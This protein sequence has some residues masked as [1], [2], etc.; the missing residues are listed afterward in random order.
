MKKELLIRFVAGKTNKIESA[1]VL[2]WADS[3]ERNYKYL[4]DLQ[5]I[6]MAQNTK[7]LEAEGISKQSKTELNFIKKKLATKYKDSQKTRIKFYKIFS[8]TSAAVAIASIV[9]FSVKFYVN[10]EKL[11]L[12]IR[13]Q[14]YTE[15]KNDQI[16]I[17]LSDLPKD[18]IKTIY[19]ERGV[20]SQIMLPDSSIVMMNSD[21][22]LTFP[23]RFVGNT[24]E[25]AI[26][27]EA[28]FKVK[29]DANRPM[30]ISTNK[31]FQIKVLGTEF[32]VKSYDNDDSAITTLYSGSINLITSNGERTI[33]IRE[34]ARI[35]SNNVV[36]ISN[37]A[38]IKDTKA[39]TEGRIIF[40]NTGMDEVIKI[41]ERWHGVNIVVKDQKILNYK[42]TANF[43]SE[44]IE[45]IMYIIKN[46]SLVD[47]CVN[48][49]DVILFS[50]PN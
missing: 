36:T 42:I 14:V 38:A 19:T 34:Q 43:N 37:K 40:D 17:A 5:L 20:K 4:I 47:Y 16:R 12:Q 21:T 25:V 41:L 49:K 24:R 10:K 32:N 50:R 28:Y 46:C 8:Y 48:G 30:I 2:D 3:N 6:Y 33:S 35:N 44:S 45:Q 27:G 15:M 11:V 31:K 1:Q 39:W 26:S 13:D 7:F 22:K 9:F 29:G 23:D 18:I